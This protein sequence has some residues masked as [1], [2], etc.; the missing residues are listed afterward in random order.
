MS[1]LDMMRSKRDIVVVKLIELLKKIENYENTLICVF[2]GKDVEY[3]GSRIDIVIKSLERENITCKGKENVLLL[4]DKVSRNNELKKAKV[5]YF[6]DKDYDYLEA[7]G[8]LYCTPC[9]SIENLYVNEYSFKRFLTDQLHISKLEDENLFNTLMA[10]FKKFELD[11]DVA[12]KELNAWLMVVVKESKADNNIKLN[13]NNT[14]ITRFFTINNF[15]VEKVYE[16]SQL[17]SI[18]NIEFMIDESYY[19]SS[20]EALERHELSLY[21]RGKYRLDYYREFLLKLISDI[22]NRRDIFEHKTLSCSLQL[23]KNIISEL[24]QHAKT[25]ECLTEFL[26]DFKS[27]NAA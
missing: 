26:Q 1:R 8:N 4:R 6:V 14:P 15:E 9:Y 2:E 7:E 18:F 12:L 20:L 19:Q 10:R 22:R 25:P 23:S 13:L 17:S 24:S 11:A 21:C 16:R 3:Y 27:I 5:I